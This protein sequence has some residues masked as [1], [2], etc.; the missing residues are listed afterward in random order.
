MKT[1][2][3]FINGTEV[4]CDVNA[5]GDDI[6][7]LLYGG[8]LPHIGSTALSVPRPSLTG[9]GISATTSILNCLGH[10]DDV[11]AKLFAEKIAA[12]TNHVTVCVCGIHVDHLSFEDLQKLYDGCCQFLEEIIH[13]FNSKE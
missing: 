1:F 2:K 7:V 3:K 5:M 11:L 10:K 13:F 6:C 9:E 4:R 12:K 8:D